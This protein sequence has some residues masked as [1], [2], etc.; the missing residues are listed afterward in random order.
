MAEFSNNKAGKIIGVLNLIIVILSLFKMM[1]NKEETKNSESGEY[2]VANFIQQ[3][4]KILSLFDLA[5]HYVIFKKYYEV[6]ALVYLIVGV[7]GTIISFLNI[8]RSDKFDILSF[9]TETT[10]SILYLKLKLVGKWLGIFYIIVAFSF[11][12]ISAIASLK[13]ELLSGICG[14]L[15]LLEG[16]LLLVFY[17]WLTLQGFNDVNTKL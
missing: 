11:S 6:I 13:I 17:F 9:L 2:I 8:D 12:L 14:I 3:I 5:I 1:L 7:I 4:I 10:C 16:I 15:V